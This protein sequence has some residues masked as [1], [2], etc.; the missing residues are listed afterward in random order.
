MSTIIGPRAQRFAKGKKCFF[1]NHTK[2]FPGP[3]TYKAVSEFGY[4]GTISTSNLSRNGIKKC[5][6]K[7]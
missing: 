7:N 2:N 5:I 3:G 1:E 6:T 4:Y